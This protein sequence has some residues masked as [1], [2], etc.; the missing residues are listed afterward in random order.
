MK[1]LGGCHTPYTPS[2]APLQA[3]WEIRKAK[4][5]YEKQLANISKSNSKAFYNYV[6]SKLRT[7]PGVSNLTRNDGTT[8]NND[9]EKASELN[10]FFSSVFTEEDLD[11]PTFQD[12]HNDVL[13]E[14][15]E[16]K[17]EDVYNY[18]KALNASKSP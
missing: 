1:L 18:L 5:E 17:E 15:V 16:I 10:K 11:L 13:L 3:R 7:K 9:Q 12:R 6:N 8:T 4:R 2:F 14:N